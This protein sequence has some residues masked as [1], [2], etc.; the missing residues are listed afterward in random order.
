M[1]CQIKRINMRILIISSLA[2]LLTF[3]CYYDNEEDLFPSLPGAC[4]TSSVSFALDVEPILSSSCYLC[5]S[6]LSAA[7][8]GGNIILDNYT[9]IADQASTVLSTIQ[10]GQGVSPM[11]KGGSKISDCKISKFEAWIDQGILEN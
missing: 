6:S 1:E 3:G 9:D 7:S 8:L 2:L 11:P 10:H 5:H 4:D